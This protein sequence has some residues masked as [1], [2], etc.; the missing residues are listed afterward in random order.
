MQ[1]IRAFEAFAGY[2]STAIAMKRLQRAFPDNVEF[3]FVGVSE[4]EPS[5]IKAYTAIHGECNN[6]GDISAISW[7]EVPDFD[8]FTWSFPCQ[9][10]SNAG[11]QGGLSKESGTVLRSHGKLYAP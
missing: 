5:A 2:G 7:R 4:I 6:Y 11:K 3:E 9:D 8:M 10:I 1:K